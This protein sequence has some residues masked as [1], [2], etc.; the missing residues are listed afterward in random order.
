MNPPA[1]SCVVTPFTPKDFVM[2]AQ[3]RGRPKQ[4]WEMTKEDVR[5]LGGCTSAD[6]KAHELLVQDA[7]QIGK[8]VPEKV[9]LDFPS[10]MPSHRFA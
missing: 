4:P 5:R 2:I 1:I 8:P 9:L 10:L 6:L 3:P 7:L